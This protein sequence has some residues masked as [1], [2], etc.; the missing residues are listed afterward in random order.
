M[1]LSSKLKV[2]YSIHFSIDLLLGF[3]EKYYYFI[4]TKNLYLIDDQ[5]F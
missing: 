5:M 2:I 4:Y 3:K 1:Y